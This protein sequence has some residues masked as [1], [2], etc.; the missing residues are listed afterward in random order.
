MSASSLRDVAARALE[1]V[2]SAGADAADVLLV[3]SDAVE[4]R[5][6]ADEIDFVKQARERTLGM[7]A[8]V[9][10]SAAL[11]R[12]SHHYASGFGLRVDRRSCA[13]LRILPLDV[14]VQGDRVLDVL[15]AELL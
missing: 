15:E 9:G 13:T 3:E 2:R 6:R 4:A 11:C 10:G 7:R 14:L 1:R 8:L 12:R 5:V